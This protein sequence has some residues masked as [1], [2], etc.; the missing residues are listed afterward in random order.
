M[1]IP[2]KSVAFALALALA[3]AFV[4]HAV[5]SPRLIS[6]HT[7]GSSFFDAKLAQTPQ[8]DGDATFPILLFVGQCVD[9]VLPNDVP[10]LH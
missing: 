8:N 2:T 3:F 10:E 7:R 5:T 4:V 9:P 6:Q 1:V